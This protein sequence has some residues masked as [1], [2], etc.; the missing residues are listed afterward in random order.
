MPCIASSGGATPEAGRDLAAYFDPTRLEELEAAMAFAW[1]TDP[2]ALDEARA[3]I[4]RALKAQTFA[5]WDD[6]GK[7]LLALAFQQSASPVT[8][9]A[10][11]EGRNVSRLVPPLRS[12]RGDH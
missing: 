10:K 9:A 8:E 2:V 4:E 5:T 3:R 6:A 12:S 1:I 7:V 11:P